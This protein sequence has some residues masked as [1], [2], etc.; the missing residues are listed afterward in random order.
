MLALLVFF[1]LIRSFNHI[2]ASELFWRNTSINSCS[3]S[4]WWNRVQVKLKHLQKRSWLSVGKTRRCLSGRLTHPNYI[5]QTP[6]GTL[7]NTAL[8]LIQVLNL[9]RGLAVN[10]LNSGISP[11][12]YSWKEET[13]AKISNRFLPSDFGL[14]LN[15]WKLFFYPLAVS[16][17]LSTSGYF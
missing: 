13:T 6:S 3:Y 17:Q 8:T 5:T 1:F 15:S 2:S 16:S 10:K 12:A 9:H 4:N 14:A 7:D 11:L